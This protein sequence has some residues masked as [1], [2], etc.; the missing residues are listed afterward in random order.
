MKFVFLF[1]FTLSTLLISAQDFI[2]HVEPPNWWVDM[3]SNEF[4]LMIHG[5]KVGECE[6]NIDHKHVKILREK[7]L[8]N[9]NYV[10]LYLEILK[11]D[12]AFDFE[13]AFSKDGKLYEEYTY[14]LYKRDKTNRRSTFNTSDVIY[15]ITPD[16]F[17]NGDQK[18]DVVKKLKEK[19][20]QDG[21]HAR[22]RQGNFSKRFAIQ[23]LCTLSNILIIGVLCYY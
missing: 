17:A 3:R 19:I 20:V 14:H 10:V 8:S 5:D 4:Q 16:R 7:R 1:S 18:N 23:V 12:M 22:T 2:Y 11:S 9:P 15:L 6:V 21:S 13:I